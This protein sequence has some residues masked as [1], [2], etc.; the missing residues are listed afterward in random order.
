V[1]RPSLITVTADNVEKT[2]FFC[3]MSARKEAGYQ[4]KLAW[5]KARFDEGLQMRL[6]GEGERGFI[7]FIPGDHAWRAIRRAGDYLV[8]HCLWVVGRSKGKGFS[9]YLIEEALAAAEAG[10]FKG[11]AAVTSRNNW[12]IDPGI[13]THHG[14]ESVAEAAPGFDIMVRKLDRAAPDPAF[15]GGW[16]KKLPGGGKGF[17][18]FRTDQCPYLDNAVNI[19]ATY[20]G[21]N[22]IAFREV[23]LTSARDVRR[24]SPTPYGVY[25]IVKDG[26]L[27]AYHY[28]SQKELAKRCG[29]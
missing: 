21:Q 20:A 25:A 1:S 22:G 9:R 16:Q 17:T 10:G 29:G 4:R 7:E 14:F 8:I 13:L 27:L 11:V 28:L 15:C 5:L 3:K 6:L 2:G 24:L 26:D 19:V 23:E 12:L 18:V